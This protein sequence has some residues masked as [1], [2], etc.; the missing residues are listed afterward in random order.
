[1]II[2]YNKN[3]NK[4]LAEYFGLNEFHCHCK[5]KFCSYTLVDSDLI[6]KLMILREAWK[7]PIPIISGYR[8]MVHNQKVKGKPGSFHMLGKAV[9]FDISSLKQ[10]IGLNKIMEDCQIFDGLGLNLKDNFVHADVRGY[11]VRF[12]Y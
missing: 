10:S 8:C 3:E 2:S 11:R 7:Q 6:D 1:M 4:K 5:N 9:D 12:N